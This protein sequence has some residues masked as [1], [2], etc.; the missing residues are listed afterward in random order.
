MKGLLSL[1]VAL[2]AFGWAAAVVAERALS[3]NDSYER[4]PV[5]LGS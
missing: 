4:T 5:T 3:K 1:A 2:A